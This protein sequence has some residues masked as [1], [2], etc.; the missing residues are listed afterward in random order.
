MSFVWREDLEKIYSEIDIVALT[1]LNEGTPVALIEAMAAGRP[2]ISTDVGGVKDLFT[3]KFK[4][5]NDGSNAMIR[6]YD[7]GILVDSDDADNMA[8]AIIELL[9]NDALRENMA[10]M[11]RKTVYPKYDI[12]RLIEDIKIFYMDLIGESK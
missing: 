8:A 11:G 5:G 12:S 6:H 3:K 1:S 9:G 7:Q 10:K 2:L 4:R